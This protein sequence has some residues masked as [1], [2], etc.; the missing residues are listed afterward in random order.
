MNNNALRKACLEIDMT[1]PGADKVKPK[2]WFKPFLQWIPTFGPYCTE[3]V[4][5]KAKGTDNGAR[6][7]INNDLNEHGGLHNN[8]PYI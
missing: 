3:F 4:Y 1:R 7:K 8:N 6:I 5:P 2:G